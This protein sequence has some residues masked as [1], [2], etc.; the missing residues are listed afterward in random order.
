ME[1]SQYIKKSNNIQYDGLSVFFSFLFAKTNKITNTDNT[2]N[3]N[4]NFIQIKYYYL[5]K[6]TVKTEKTHFI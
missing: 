4:N 6:T 2:D 1:I 3:I 5:F